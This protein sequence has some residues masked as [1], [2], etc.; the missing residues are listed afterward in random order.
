MGLR[1]SSGRRPKTR[2]GELRRRDASLSTWQLSSQYFQCNS[3]ATVNW[4]TPTSLDCHVSFD[5]RPGS[6]R[7]GGRLAVGLEKSP[8]FGWKNL[9]S[10]S[11]SSDTEVGSTESTSQPHLP[12]PPLPKGQV[13]WSQVTPLEGPQTQILAS[14]AARLHR[15][16]MRPGGSA[17]LTAGCSR[18]NRSH[19]LLKTHCMHVCSNQTSLNLTG[20]PRLIPNGTGESLTIHPPV[21]QPCDRVSEVTSS[22]RPRCSGTENLGPIGSGIPA[23][24]TEG[25]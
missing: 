5:L 12:A 15:S 22:K 18:T 24:R 2:P 9:I 8:G 19:V 10:S 1:P 16:R 4:G 11:G 14:Q 23:P 17:I 6:S 25:G 7:M 3:V 20:A 21:S 13:I